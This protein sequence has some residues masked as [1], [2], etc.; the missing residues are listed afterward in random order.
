ML[1]L[2]EDYRNESEQDLL[3]IDTSVIEAWEC[4][5]METK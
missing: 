4:A 3:L 5:D 2:P 1:G